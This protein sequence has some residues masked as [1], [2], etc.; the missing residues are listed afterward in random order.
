MRCLVVEDEPE[1][2][3]FISR[4]IREMNG[5]VDIVGTLADAHHAVASFPYDLAV[6]DRRLPDGDAIDLL[7]VLGKLGQRPGVLLLTAM[8]AKEDVIDG[9]NAGADDYLVKPFEPQELIARARA[10]LRRPRA[11]QADV[12]EL[13]NLRYSTGTN[14]VTVNDQPLLLRRREAVI[15]ETLM[16]R[17]NRVVSRNVLVEAVYGFDDD[18]ESNSLE[19]HV[20]RLRKRLAEAGSDVEIRSMRGIGYILRRATQA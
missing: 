7:K 11:Q 5:I 2:A 3:S 15:F 18:I 19:A 8:D 12:L 1:I 6:V 13:G 17:Q 16:L 10:I 14:E 9:L 20:S 4:L